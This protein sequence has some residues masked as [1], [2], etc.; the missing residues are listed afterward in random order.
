MDKKIFQ[1]HVERL[2][3]PQPLPYHG[4]TV[5]FPEQEL[6]P[7]R[8]KPCAELCTDCNIVV[9]NRRIEYRRW[10]NSQNDVYTWYKKCYNC[11]S[12]VQ[13]RCLKRLKNLTFSDKT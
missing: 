1:I 8:A 9:V 11:K 10:Y 6:P 2:C 3:D 7:Y 5:D 13:S 4:R 12:E